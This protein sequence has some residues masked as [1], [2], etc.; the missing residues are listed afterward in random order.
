MEQPQNKY[1]QVE[2]AK[3]IVS[4]KPHAPEK[5][6]SDWE[7]ENIDQLIPEYRR[8]ANEAR[9]ALAAW[10]KKDITFKVEGRK[11]KVDKNSNP[12]AKTRWTIQEW[13]KTIAQFVHVW[14]PSVE[15][16]EDFLTKIIANTEA[17]S[18]P[19]VTNPE[20][21]TFFEKKTLKI[22]SLFLNEHPR[23]IAEYLKTSQYF[24][25][26]AKIIIGDVVLDLWGSMEQLVDSLMLLKAAWRDKD[27]NKVPQPAFA[28]FVKLIQ[29]GKIGTTLMLTS[30]P[31]LNKKQPVYIA[32]EGLPEYAKWLVKPV[33]SYVA[34]QPKE[35]TSPKEPILAHND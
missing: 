15:N 11:G 32:D 3:K 1:E 18:L 25:P 19:S 16:I 21:I 30:K 33:C 29:E 2:Q 4:D 24:T 13:W 14:T 12:Q 5:K 35:N 26:D 10:W 23:A 20:T 17:Q 7:E 22:V 27:G 8:V 34:L 28:K 31:V 6:V 9:E